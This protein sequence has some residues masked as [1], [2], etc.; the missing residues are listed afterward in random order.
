MGNIAAHTHHQ[1]RDAE[2]NA[3]YFDMFCSQNA[4]EDSPLAGGPNP[5]RFPSTPQLLGSKMFD[6]INICFYT[7]NFRRTSEANK[8][9]KYF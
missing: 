6:S 7:N 9:K 3:D 1:N 2:V 4:Y 8:T 5:N